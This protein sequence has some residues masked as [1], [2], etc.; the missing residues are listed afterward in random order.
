MADYKYDVAFSFL[1]RDEELAYK[2]S[3]ELSTRLKTF[4]YSEKQIELAGQDGE[5]TF[6]QIF[7]IE[8]RVVVVLFRSE[9]GNTKWTRI[10]QT[11]IRNRGFQ[12]GYDFVFF[13]IIEPES[14]VPEWIPKSQLWYNYSRF[15]VD[16]ITAS[17]ENKLQTMG[18]DTRQPTIEEKASLLNK[19]LASAR[20]QKEFLESEKAVSVAHIEAGILYSSV[21]EH[22]QT[23]SK[24]N[25]ELRG[26]MTN[27]RND[28]IIKLFGYQLFVHWD[29]YYSSSLNDSTLHIWLSEIDRMPFEWDPKY[30][31][32]IKHEFDFSMS[33][34]DDYGWRNRLSRE[35]FYSSKEL[36]EFAINLLINAVASYRLK[37]LKS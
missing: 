9:W 6:N 4:V 29:P 8:A 2:I 3:E 24:D 14:I 33:I 1:Q 10:E 22:Y 18:V 31:Y 37:E 5:I 25:S 17:I 12:D 7:G 34:S 11:A 28:I 15:G 26:E 35:R 21:I 36:A 20:F 32:I 27:E 19:K 16:G 13:I 30:H 23:I